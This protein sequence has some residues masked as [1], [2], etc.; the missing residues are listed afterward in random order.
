M[1]FPGHKRSELLC[2][3]LKIKFVGGNPLIGSSLMHCSPAD[4]AVR[5]DRALQAC[6]A[7]FWTA[8]SPR[9]IRDI[10]VALP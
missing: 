7:L 4:K 6:R 3:F 5:L 2:N 8:A 9:T 1:T 10:C